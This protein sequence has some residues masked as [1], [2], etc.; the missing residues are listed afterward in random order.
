MCCS[1]VQVLIQNP[2]TKEFYKG[3]GKWTHERC[4]ALRFDTPTAAALKCHQ[5]KLAADIL[6]RFDGSTHD[7][8]IPS[9]ERKKAE[10][11]T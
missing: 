2:T 8:I 3:F 7:T 4:A 11:E 10:G 1:V 9:H 6:L 5:D